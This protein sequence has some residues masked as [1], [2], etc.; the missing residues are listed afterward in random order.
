VWKVIHSP[1]TA[2]VTCISVRREKN[3]L[4]VAFVYTY[5]QLRTCVCVYIYIYMLV[6]FVELALC[7]PSAA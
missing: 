3:F 6:L 4:Q 2:V 5:G 7:H 1:A